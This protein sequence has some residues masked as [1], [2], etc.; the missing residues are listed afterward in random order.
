VDRK[1]KGVVFCYKLC[2]GDGGGKERDNTGYAMADSYVC[3]K[4]GATLADQP[5][6]LMRLAECV[7]CRAD[8]HVCYLCE[9]Y[10]TRVAGTCREPLAEEVQDKQRA[11][12]CGYFQIKAGAYR[13]GDEEVSRNARAKL[14]DLFSGNSNGTVA[15]SD[16]TDSYSKVDEARQRLERLFG[17][18][19]D[20]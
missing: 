5:G 8:L 2:E 12:F 20:I 15:D 19:A 13:L 11:N 3:W 4:C 16:K 9:F 14:E 18:K 10:D 6:T 7:S 1:A 17:R